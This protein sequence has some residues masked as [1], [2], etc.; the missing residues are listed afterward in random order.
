MTT[1]FYITPSGSTSASGTIY[2]NSSNDP[3]SWVSMGAGSYAY[4]SSSNSSKMIFSYSDASNNP[5]NNTINFP[6][7][8]SKNYSTNG[9]LTY[10]QGGDY[11]AIPSINIKNYANQDSSGNS[12]ISFTYIGTSVN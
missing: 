8:G 4:S 1:L 12:T 11:V 7:D 9:S 5:I 6:Y 2:V 10:L 3:S